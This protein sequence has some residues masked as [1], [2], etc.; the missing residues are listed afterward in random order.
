MEAVGPRLS[1]DV[2]DVVCPVV[3]AVRVDAEFEGDMLER[4]GMTPEVLETARMTLVVVVAVMDSHLVTVS[5]DIDGGTGMVVTGLAVESIP[6]LVVEIEATPPGI[7]V[8][9]SANPIEA[10]KKPPKGCAAGSLPVT[11]FSSCPLY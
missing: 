2:V 4:L 3:S 9:G 7:V 1:A 10:E 5:V 6:C 11:G 8:E